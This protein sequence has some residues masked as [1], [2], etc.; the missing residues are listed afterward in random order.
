MEARPDPRGISIEAPASNTSPSEYEAMVE[1]AKEYIR[2]GDIF[3]VVLS[4][5]FE[6]PFPL[7]PFALYRSLR[8]VNPAPFLCYLDFNEFQIVC[9]SPEILVRVRDGKVTIRPI[10]GTRPRGASPA[11]DRA[12]AESLLADPKE[13]RKSTR[14][15]SSHANIS[16]AVFCLKKKKTLHS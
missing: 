6:A 1:R 11:E 5:R 14:L 16:Y 8:R 9:S 13:D 12:H 3:Q 2:A 4:Q 7:P 15:N 10:A